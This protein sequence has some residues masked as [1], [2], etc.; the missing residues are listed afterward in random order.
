MERFDIFIT[1]VPWEN[2]GKRRPALAYVIEDESVI[3]FPITTQYEN[4]SDATKARYFAITDWRQSGLDKQ[5]YVDTGTLRRIGKEAFLK[6]Q[7]GKL[8]EADKQ[9]LLEFLT[10]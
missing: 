2:G 5:S 6:S 9:R 8:T 4:K 7:I 1:Y 3:V 10:R